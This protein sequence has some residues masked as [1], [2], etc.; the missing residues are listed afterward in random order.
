MEKKVKRELERT[1]VS[2][3]KLYRKT[4]KFSAEGISALARLARAI[5][6]HEKEIH[7]PTNPGNP[8]FHSYLEKQEGPRKRN[9][10]RKS[11]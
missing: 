11:S 5:S 8:N 10:K 3:S 2:A 1:L 4:G 6:V 7:N 9:L